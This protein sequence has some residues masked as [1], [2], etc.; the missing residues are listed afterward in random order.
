[1][2]LLGTAFLS[3]HTWFP[4]YPLLTRVKFV[5]SRVSSLVL[6]NIAGSGIETR[7]ASTFD[8]HF[9]EF[10]IG[11]LFLCRRV[12]TLIPVP[13]VSKTNY[14]SYGKLRA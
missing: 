2:D 6:Q 5:Q 12:Q 11:I 4:P 1:M 13:R 8:S 3:A 10:S 14:Q 9:L 7:V